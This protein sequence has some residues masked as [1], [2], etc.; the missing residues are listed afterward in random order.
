MDTLKQ[1]SKW[2]SLV[3]ELIK[4]PQETEWIEFKHNNDAPDMIGENI[5]ALS[6]VSALLG[7]KQAYMVWGVHDGTHEL[8]GTSFVPSKAKHKQQ[9]LE[10]W[11][12]QKLSPKINFSFYEVECQEKAVVILEIQPASN[13]P[14]RFDGTEYIRIGSNTKKLRDFPEKE[15]ELWRVFDRVPFE[16]QTALSQ[17][18]KD[19]ILTLL[20]YA[21]YFRLLNQPI[22]ENHSRILENL[23]DDGIIHKTDTNLWDI[24]NL[25]AIL[26]ANKLSDFK[27]LSRKAIRIILY[28]GHNK[29]E[30]IKEWSINKGY[31]VGYES[32][33]ETLNLLL[34]SKEVIGQALRQEKSMYPELALREL[35]ANALIHQDFHLTG[36]SPMIEIYEHRIEITNPGSSLI[37]IERLMDKPPRSRNEGIASLMR[38]MGICEERGSGIDKVVAQTEI[39]QLPAPLFEMDDYTKATLFAYRHFKDLDKEEKIRACYLHS[40]LKYLSQEPMN[41][42]TMRERF[43]ISVENSAMISRVIKQTVEAGVIKAYDTNAGTKAMRYIPFWA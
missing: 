32:I 2:Q 6:N 42:T 7:K 4:L 1:T 15:R 26:F 19:Q 41:N 13:T 23:A 27:Q 24:S 40:V 43:G 37:A 12:L 38:R 33:I 17:Q 11:L 14:V 10:S 34:P 8:L 18:S 28:K 21:T 35:I 39:H 16:E 5:S 20:D 36:T 31:A 9:E 29:L 25:G 22:P 30:T 3:T